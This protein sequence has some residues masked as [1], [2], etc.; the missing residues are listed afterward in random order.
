MYTLFTKINLHEVDL[1]Y[2]SRINIFLEID[3]ED[4]AVKSGITL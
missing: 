4:N 1:K 3:N 2:M